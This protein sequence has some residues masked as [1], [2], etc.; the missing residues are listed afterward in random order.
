[1][2]DRSVS[3]NSILSPC[4]CSLD[5]KLSDVD[6]ERVACTLKW[7]EVNREMTISDVLLRKVFART[8]GSRDMEYV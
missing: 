5:R 4:K 2:D 8:G 3:W 7:L 6:L 1:M